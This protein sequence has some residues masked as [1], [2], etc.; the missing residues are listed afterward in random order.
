M[1][2]LTGLSQVSSSRDTLC[3][4]FLSQSRASCPPSNPIG[5]T[6]AAM[7]LP[8]GSSYDGNGLMMVRP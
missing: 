2:F 5:R 3:N 7:P 8:L 6:P 1:T 4:S